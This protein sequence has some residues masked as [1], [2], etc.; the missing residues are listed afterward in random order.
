MKPALALLLLSSLGYLVAGSGISRSIY[1]ENKK[2]FPK[3]K[4]VL[5]GAFGAH[6]LALIVYSLDAGHLP[7]HQLQE[8]F[9]PLAWF[10]MLLYLVL[11]ERW[12]VEVAGAVAA[13]A[14]FAMTG[15]SIFALWRGQAPAQLGPGTYV[16][17]MCLVVGFA[18]LFLASACALLYFVQDRLLK[19]KRL[20]G[21][22]RA[23]PPLGTI[24]QV[25]YRLIWV[26]FP[27]LV[28]GIASGLYIQGG[29]WGWGTHE[30]VVVLTS[31]VYTFYLHARLIGWQGRRLNA[32]LIA[33]SAVAAI[34]FLLPGG[35]H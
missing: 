5:W 20:D 9:A 28:V 24:D 17:V 18:S 16:H 26:G 29:H 30:T 35:H 4:K 14:A 10:V 32:I 12:K 8:T 22:Y 7:L 15:F 3:W 21:L 11:G 6:T 13:P 33:A 27:A 31:L 34:S 1:V 2:S 23:L 19:Q 25:T